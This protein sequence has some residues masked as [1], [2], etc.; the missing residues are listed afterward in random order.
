MAT[1]E[2]MQVK[3]W[4]G[5]SSVGAIVDDDPEA[6]FSIAFLTGDL[7]DFEHHVAE[8]VLVFGAGEGNPGDGFLRNQEKVNRSLRR[9]VAETK[10]KVIFIDNLGGDFTGDDFLKKRGF[11]A[12]DS[13]VRWSSR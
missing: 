1:G 11:V 3:V 10:A 7:T 8:Q 12:H 13:T 2:E 9:N 4:H 6:F 5:F